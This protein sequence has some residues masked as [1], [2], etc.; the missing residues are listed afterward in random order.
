MYKQLIACFLQQIDKN[1]ISLIRFDFECHS[2]EQTFVFLLYLT[3]LHSFGSL[4][5][6]RDR[7]LLWF[8]GPKL[9]S[10]IEVVLFGCLS[11]DAVFF[12]ARLCAAG[13]QDL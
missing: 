13:E 1:Y 10:G 8:W 12:F 4:W 7:V 2:R 11:L 9:T 3:E 5:L 6:L